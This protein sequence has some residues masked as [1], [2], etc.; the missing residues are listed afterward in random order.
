VRQLGMERRVTFTGHLSTEA[1]AR[2]FA[3]CDVVCLPSV[4]RSEMYGMVQLE[5]MV[6]GKPLIV[7]AI[8]RSGTRYVV[9]DGVTGIAV[10]PGDTVALARALRTLGESPA[11]RAD[12]GA[13]GRRLFFDEYTADKMVERHIALYRDVLG[14]NSERLG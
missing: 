7:S 11:L 5:A 4:E 1:L 10:P 6:F 14:R 3:R 8:P 2:E 13:A 12:Y 9:R